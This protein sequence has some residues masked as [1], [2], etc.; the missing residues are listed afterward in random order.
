MTKEKV[1]PRLQIKVDGEIVAQEVHIF[2]KDYKRI[3]KRYTGYIQWPEDKEL[4]EEID[5]DALTNFIMQ[6]K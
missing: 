2:D 3:G 5:V 4:G 1:K 6:K